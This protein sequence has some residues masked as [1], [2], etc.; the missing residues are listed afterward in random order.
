MTFK[1][2][3]LQN[4]T[5]IIIP[6]Y[7]LALIMHLPVWLAEYCG[8]THSCSIFLPPFSKRSFEED[9]LGGVLAYTQLSTCEDGAVGPQVRCCLFL[10]VRPEVPL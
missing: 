9:V 6:L 10:F 4:L 1:C 2:C 7:P 8:C 3:L 5:P